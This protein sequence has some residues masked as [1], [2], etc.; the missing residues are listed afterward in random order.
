MFIEGHAVAQL[1]ETLCYEL[2]ESGFDSVYLILPAALIQ[3]STQPL[4]EMSTRNLCGGNGRPALK[5]D[6]PT[7]ICESSKKQLYLVLLNAQT[8]IC[9]LWNR[10]GNKFFTRS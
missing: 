7:A 10:N 2:E 6:N 9:V 3:G 8:S 5:A 1:V 4:A